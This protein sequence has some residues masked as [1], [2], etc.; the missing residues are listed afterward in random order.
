MRCGSWRLPSTSHHAH[1]AWFVAP[2]IHIHHAHTAWF[3]APAIHITPCPHGFAATRQRWPFEPF[4]ETWQE[5]LPDT[6]KTD[7]KYLDVRCTAEHAVVWSCPYPCTR[8][9]A[10]VVWSCGRVVVPLPCDAPVLSGGVGLT[11]YQYHLRRRHGGRGQRALLFSRV[12]PQHGHEKAG[13]R[14]VQEAGH[15]V[16]R[17][18]LALPQVNKSNHIGRSAT[19]RPEQRYAA[20]FLRAC[21]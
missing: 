1:A 10:C 20:C 5:R 4:M 16:H 3:V 14:T 17:G 15:L 9:A 6:M 19:L 11:D 8:R 2:A 7:L 21:F 18:H 12:D 13:G